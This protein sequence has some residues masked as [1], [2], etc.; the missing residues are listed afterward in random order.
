MICRRRLF[1][2][3]EDKV[4]QDKNG[5]Q[6]YRFLQYMVQMVGWKNQMSWEAYIL[7]QQKCYA[8]YATGDNERMFSSEKITDY[9]PFAFQKK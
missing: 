8:L 7:W 2:E 9:E 6:F 3:H 4:I 5:E 1:P